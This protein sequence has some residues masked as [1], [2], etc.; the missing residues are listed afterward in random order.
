LESY[1]RKEIDGDI[2]VELCEQN[3]V[4]K[5]FLQRDEHGCFVLRLDSVLIGSPAELWPAIVM[6]IKEGSEESKGEII[7]WLKAHSKHRG[8][9]KDLNEFAGLYD[10]LMKNYF[11]TLVKPNLKLGKRGK[12]GQQKSIRLAS[13]WPHKKEIVLHPFLKNESVPISYIEY[14]IFHELC[15]ALFIYSGKAKDSKQHGPEFYQLEKK[16]PKIDEALQWEKESLPAL[17]EDFFK[18]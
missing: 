1:L 8:I 15:H 9:D 6:F 5:F 14:V 13:F 7:E 10:A 18:S 12:Y 11:P 16:Y 17:L 4:R 3:T 2:R